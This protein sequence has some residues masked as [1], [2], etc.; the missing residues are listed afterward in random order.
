MGGGGGGG[1]AS[2]YHLAQIY[3]NVHMFRNIVGDNFIAFDHGYEVDP[4]SRNL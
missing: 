2:R 3:A 4:S 1:C